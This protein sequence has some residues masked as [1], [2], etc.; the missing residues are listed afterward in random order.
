MNIEGTGINI[1]WAVKD[2]QRNERVKD[3]K[4]WRMKLM[5]CR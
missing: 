1:Q 2:E 4:R 5:H 3:K